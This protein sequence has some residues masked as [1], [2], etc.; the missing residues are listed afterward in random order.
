MTE[1]SAAAVADAVAA[2]HTEEW[3]RIVATLIRIT[4][5]W[6]LAEDCA[7]DA[8]ATALERWP[9]DGI[10]P[11]PGGWLTTVAKNRAIDRLRRSAKERSK[12]A[13]ASRLA[14]A[15]VMDELQEPT[16][17][18]VADDRL[19]LIFTCCHP[20]LGLEARIALTLRTVA[21]LSTPQ[22][23]RAFLVPEPTMAQRLVRAK[24]K[25]RNAGIP[26]RVPEGHLLGE[27]LP[28]VLAVLYLLFNEGYSASGGDSLLRADLAA[29]AIRLARLLVGLMPDEPEAAGLLALMLLQHARR[30]ARTD[31][32][33]DLVP[34][35]DQDRG[36]WNAA[37]IA[38]GVG[39]LKAALRREQPGRYQLQAVIA[40]QHATAPS[41]A[42][43][44]FPE[45]LHAW[46]ELVR[47][48][49]SPVVA[50]NRAIAWGIWKGP[51]AGLEAVDRV[52]ALDGYYLLPA[53]RADLLR[54][55]G[56]TADAAAAY[57]EALA[58]APTEPERRYLARRLREC[59]A[60]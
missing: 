1:T 39:I 32:A 5:D 28:G 18:N 10:P 7:Q 23:A 15:D 8:F 19:R 30:E 26:Y 20:A 3:G 37:M 24:S 54:R 16:N 40:A 49:P 59:P 21:G 46:D 38:E 48:D 17:N 47:I 56:R 43:T 6:S 60:D 42:E 52:A 22:I 33:G 44:N 45:L 13:E 11:N 25:I 2:A 36:L 14:E 12:L 9:R 31:T 51:A 29:E 57:R 50:L 58:L 35:E 55:L 27:R 53:A 41:L 34:L 4:G